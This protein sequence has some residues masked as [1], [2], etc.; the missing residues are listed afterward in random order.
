MLAKHKVGSSTLL[1]RSIFK[2]LVFQGLFYF[3]ELLKQARATFET[4]LFAC[5]TGEAQRSTLLWP[6]ADLGV[7]NRQ[8][9]L[10]D[11]SLILRV[12]LEIGE[13]LSRVFASSQQSFRAFM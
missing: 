5:P 11:H 12:D 2:P 7:E 9:D 3:A 4:E 10:P 1:T 8:D 6:R 13:E